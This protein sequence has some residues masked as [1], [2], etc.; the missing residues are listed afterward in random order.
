MRKG[1]E[2]TRHREAETKRRKSREKKNNHE[3]GRKYRKKKN[4][5]KNNKQ[6][7]KRT[8]KG[9]TKTGQ[10]NT[11]LICTSSIDSNR[12][13]RS[14]HYSSTSEGTPFTLSRIRFSTLSARSLRRIL[15]THGKRCPR[16]QCGLQSIKTRVLSRERKSPSGKFQPREVPL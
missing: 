2:H 4:K 10:K 14:I 11:L 16:G 5:R 9:K 12:Y 7:K 6:G 15:L 3:K 1:E 8:Q 13:C